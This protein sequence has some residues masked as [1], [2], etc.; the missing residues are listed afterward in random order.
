M[1]FFH[2]NTVG[3]K[4][5]INVGRFCMFRSSARMPFSPLSLLILLRISAS[6]QKQPTSCTNPSGFAPVSAR[7][8]METHPQ[9]TSYLLRPSPPA[10]VSHLHC[11]TP[12]D[13]STPPPPNKPHHNR[14]KRKRTDLKMLFQTTKRMERGNHFSASFSLKQAK[15]SIF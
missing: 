3:A 14:L 11:K 8:G 1:L 7:W 9:F 15:A 6:F 4:Q 13:Y 2:I 12:R 5:K 10:A